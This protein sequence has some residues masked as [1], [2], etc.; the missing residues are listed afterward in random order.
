M[1]S[2]EPGEF[3]T[4]YYDG[5]EHM[6]E[7]WKAARRESRD[8]ELYAIFKQEYDPSRWS[9]PG[10]FDTY[11]EAKKYLEGMTGKSVD[12]SDYVDE[13]NERI[14]YHIELVRNFGE[15]K[16]QMYCLLDN[17]A[18]GRAPYLS[19]AS[20]EI[21]KLK[22]L[23][24]AEDETGDSW[25]DGGGEEVALLEEIGGGVSGAIIKAEYRGQP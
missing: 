18:D 5:I 17:Y 24:M 8:G 11:D 10:L 25:A 12:E 13:D 6:P 3:Y 4:E 21:E 20:E 2:R 22:S 19:H 7:T 16:S 1:R 23:V 9:C 14:F 15:T